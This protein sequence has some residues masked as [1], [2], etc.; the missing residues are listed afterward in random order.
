[1]IRRELCALAIRKPSTCNRQPNLAK[2][3]R[4]SCLT[5]FVGRI[6]H[7]SYRPKSLIRQGVKPLTVAIVHS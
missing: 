5:A 7:R 2:A 4:R 6:E 1:M 3:D